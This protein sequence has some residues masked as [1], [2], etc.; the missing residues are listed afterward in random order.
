MPIALSCPTATGKSPVCLTF[1]QFQ[2][3]GGG[4]SGV[5]RKKEPKNPLILATQMWAAEGKQLKVLKF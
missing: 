1:K 3:G 2:R 4:V 5:T